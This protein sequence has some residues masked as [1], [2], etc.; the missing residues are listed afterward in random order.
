L[1]Y[2]SAAYL[3]WDIPPF[4]F[5]YDDQWVS[6]SGAGLIGRKRDGILWSRLRLRTSQSLSQHRHRFDL[7][8]HML[9]HTAH[10][11]ILSPLFEAVKSIES[12]YQLNHHLGGTSFRCEN[13]LLE[14]LERVSATLLNHYEHS[15]NFR[16]VE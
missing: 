3:L 7:G 9:L 6:R 15:K 16:R 11:P 8:K 13:S 2:D 14:L 4:D 1:P 12:D 10:S 5:T